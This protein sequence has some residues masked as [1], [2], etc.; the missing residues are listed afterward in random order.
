MS[1][2]P[3][4]KRTIHKHD[5]PSTILPEGQRTIRVYL[6]PGFQA[7]ISYPVVY[8]QDGE[9][10]FNFGRIATHAQRLIL[11][12]DWD[13]FIIVGVEVDKSQRT[14]EYAPDGE[15][16]PLYTRFFAEEMVP[17]VESH[18]PV[19]DTPEMRLLAGDSLGGAVSLSLALAYPSLFNRI[20]SL[21][22]AFYEAYFEQLRQAGSLDRL[23]LWMV[24]GLQETAYPTDRGTFDFVKLNRDAVRLL[25]EKGAKL[26]YAEKEGEHKW[27]FWQQQLPE[28]LAAFLGPAPRLFE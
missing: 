16:Y 20:L 22:G 23:K 12:E 27:G 7:W 24:V 4:Y 28:A 13:P 10:F 26:H 17:W 18:Y 1:D 3:L 8:C 21:S 11:E 14:S 2:N 19:R 9:D 15:R 5:I 25:E 6:P